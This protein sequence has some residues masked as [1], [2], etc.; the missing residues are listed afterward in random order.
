META[1]THVNKEIFSLVLSIMLKPFPPEKNSTCYFYMDADSKVTAAVTLHFH[2]ITCICCLSNSRIHSAIKPAVCVQQYAYLRRGQES[3]R[4]PT[5]PTLWPVDSVDCIS[6]SVNMHP[7]CAELP[8]CNQ[9]FAV[10]CDAWWM[11]SSALYFSVSSSFALCPQIP[12]L[13]LVVR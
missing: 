6:L 8:L 12:S 3:L 4:I 7:H 2:E 5:N 1:T 10:G 13:H 9:A 11:S